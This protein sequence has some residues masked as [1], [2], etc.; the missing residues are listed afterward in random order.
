MKQVGP[1]CGTTC[2]AMALEYHG[3]PAHA[4]I[5]EP[6]I[7]PYG[8]LDLGE[9]PA[10]LARYARTLGFSAQ[11]YNHGDADSLGQHLQRGRTVTVMPNYRG[12]TAHILNVL[13]V[14]HDA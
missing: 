2:L 5:I 4:D 14:R 11:H 7:H 6:Y 13:A 8:N 10:E 3:F 1:S 9:V 12:G